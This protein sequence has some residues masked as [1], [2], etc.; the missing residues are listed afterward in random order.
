M[1]DRLFLFLLKVAVVL[2]CGLIYLQQDH[3]YMAYIYI[4][5]IVH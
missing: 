3:I 2:I 1:I 5:G 4:P